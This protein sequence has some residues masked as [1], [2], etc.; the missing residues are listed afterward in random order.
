MYLVLRTTSRDHACASWRR[1]RSRSC[2]SYTSATFPSRHGTPRRLHIGSL[3][4]P[5]V[6]Q[7]SHALIRPLGRRCRRLL[8]RRGVNRR[9]RRDGAYRDRPHRN[10]ESTTSA[11]GGGSGIGLYRR[12]TTAAIRRRQFPLHREARKTDRGSVF[13]ARLIRN[14]EA[15]RWLLGRVC[16]ESG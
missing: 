14:T 12:A 8:T 15:R 6:D 2:T 11:A 9:N 1:S 5:L 13:C 16:R 10:I 4:L 7:A 3:A